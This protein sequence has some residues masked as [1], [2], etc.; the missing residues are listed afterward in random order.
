MID[1]YRMKLFFSFVKLPRDLRRFFFCLEPFA[2]PAVSNVCLRP[3][4]VLVWFVTKLFKNFIERNTY[5]FSVSW[6]SSRVCRSETS[7][8]F[9]RN[10]LAK[11]FVRLLR[12]DGRSVCCLLNRR[13]V[14]VSYIVNSARIL[15]YL[16]YF[17][18]KTIIKIVIAASFVL[19]QIVYKFRRN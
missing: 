19:F 1:V 11:L 8:N 13:V 2:K 18:V 4:D 7:K 6:V 16:T 15:L 12:T 17:C 5:Y 10:F 9:I 14:V 3:K